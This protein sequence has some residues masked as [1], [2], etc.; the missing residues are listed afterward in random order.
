MYNGLYVR[1][2]NGRIR[3]YI[4]E[5]FAKYMIEYFHK[6]QGHIGQK[7]TALHFSQNY[8]TTN[9]NQ[10][11]HEIVYNCAICLQAKRPRKKLGKLSQI[12]PAKKP[13]EYVHI[14]T[15]GGLRDQGTTNRYFHVAID[16]FTRYVWGLYSKTQNAN[17]FIKLYEEVRKD[18]IPQKIITDDLNRNKLDP[19]YEGPFEIINRS[20]DVIYVLNVAGN[21][22]TSHIENMKPVEHKEQVIQ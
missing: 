21:D 2:T 3:Y 5:D 15:I 7:Q 13:F 17:D 1:Y 19:R 11:I 12:G 22:V 18:G 8:Y 14:D 6:V 4:P 10:I 16:A 20:S 9:Q